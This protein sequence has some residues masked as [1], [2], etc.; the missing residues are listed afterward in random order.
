METC[1]STGVDAVL[2]L[3]LML[4]IEEKETFPFFGNDEP[5][6]EEEVTDGEMV[7]SPTLNPVAAFDSL[8]A[9]RRL[10]SK[11]VG[12]SVLLLVDARVVDVGLL[13]FMI[14]GRFSVGTLS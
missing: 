3:L 12:S 1:E 9:L 8:N 2:A 4:S 14:F 5:V 13:A 6:E 7:E 11:D 10:L